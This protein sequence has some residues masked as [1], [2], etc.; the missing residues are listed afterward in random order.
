[1]LLR[2]KIFYKYAF[3]PLLWVPYW[4]ASAQQAATHARASKVANTENALLWEISGKNLQQTSYLFGTFHLITSD[5]LK[6]L[7]LVDE[8]LM[9]AQAVVGEMVMDSAVMMK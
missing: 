5:Y 3:L 1:M 4:S 6:N 2:K 8:K 7:P 9:E